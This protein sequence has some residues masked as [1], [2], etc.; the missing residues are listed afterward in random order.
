M[1]TKLDDLED[2]AAVVLVP[3]EAFRR[4]L[5]AADPSLEPD[6]QEAFELPDSQTVVLVPVPEDDE[7]LEEFLL[8]HKKDL[9]QK[10]IENW[11]QDPAR[12]PAVPADAFDDWFEVR[13]HSMVVALGEE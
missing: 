7:E 13:F 8:P 3:T 6:L 5:A 11:I 9:A 10:E 2:L 4:V 12:R 1:S